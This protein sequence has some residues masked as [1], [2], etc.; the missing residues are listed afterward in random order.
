MTDGS[1]M[2]LWGV[3]LRCSFNH[4]APLRSISPLRD[5]YQRIHFGAVG[6]FALLLLGFAIAGS[7]L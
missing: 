2:A 3:V 7:A 6:F 4:V 1:K 5:S